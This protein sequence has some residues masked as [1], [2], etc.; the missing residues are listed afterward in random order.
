MHEAKIIEFAK[1]LDFESGVR[2]SGITAG[3]PI[4][5]KSIT[6]GEIKQ[7]IAAVLMALPPSQRREATRLMKKLEQRLLAD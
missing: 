4:D 1:Q 3:D 5:S 6:V 7:H 2:S